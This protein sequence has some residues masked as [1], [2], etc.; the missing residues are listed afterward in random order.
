MS[1]T[2]KPLV[3]VA[4]MAPDNWGWKYYNANHLGRH[5]FHITQ[6][7]DK[8]C[9][10]HSGNDPESTRHPTIAAAKQAAQT[11]WDLFIRAAVEETP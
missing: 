1:L 10:L 7:A 2:V 6:M 5:L 4:E 8:S 9:A 3:W 11:E